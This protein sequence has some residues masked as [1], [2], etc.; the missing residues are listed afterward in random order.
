MLQCSLFL[1]YN[2]LPRWRNLPAGRGRL[3]EKNARV[4][5]LADALRSGRSESN[6]MGVQ[7]SPRALERYVLYISVKKQKS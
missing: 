7:V 5:K 4:A 6:L 1:E 3:V 2:V